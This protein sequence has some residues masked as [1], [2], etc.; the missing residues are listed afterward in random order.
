MTGFDASGS[1]TLMHVGIT[2]TVPAG[3]VPV[4]YWFRE[5]FTNTLPNLTWSFQAAR[6]N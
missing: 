6:Q 3:G 1:C 5:T 2:A 4:V